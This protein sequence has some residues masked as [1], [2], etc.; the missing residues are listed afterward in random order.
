MVCA[1]SAAS[2]TLVSV[3]RSEG[4][5]AH[6]STTCASV[7]CAA[8]TA[9][10]KKSGITEAIMQDLLSAAL[11]YSSSTYASKPTASKAE[12]SVRAITAYRDIKPSY[13]VRRDTFQL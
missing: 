6:I 9:T 13:L 4:L 8:P 11:Y 7:K 10:K 12:R 3:V 1:Q 5:L 2:R